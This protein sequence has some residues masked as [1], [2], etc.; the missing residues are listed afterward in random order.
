MKYKINDYDLVK[1]EDI[2]IFLICLATFVITAG[3]HLGSI[4]LGFAHVSWFRFYFVMAVLIYFIYRI[5]NQ[6]NIIIWKRNN[7]FSVSYIFVWVLYAVM[8]IIWSRNLEHFFSVLWFL[9]VGAL[10]TVIFVDICNIERIIKIIISFELGL[11]IQSVFGLYEIVTGKYFFLNEY[12]SGV[13]ASYRIPVAM[14]SNA[15]DYGTAMF[16]GALLA[17]FL[18]VTTTNKIQKIL[19]LFLMLDY[20]IMVYLSGSRAAL[21]GF[22]FAIGILVW[23]N[24]SDGIRGIIVILLLI[25]FILPV[26]RNAFIGHL[27]FSYYTTKGE[28]FSV[29][30]NLIKNGLYF[31]VKTFGLGVGN[32]QIELWMNDSAMYY[33]KNILNMHNWWLEILTAYGIIIFLGFLLFYAKLL[34]DYYFYYLNDRKG[35]MGKQALIMFSILIGYSITS[36][37]SSSNVSK[38]YIWLF[39]AICITFQG[40][41]ITEK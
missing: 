36:V 31:V 15:N 34:I 14:L 39:W 30:T 17:I 2:I 24:A 19:C 40:I 11:F 12:N 41:C 1:I 20:G 3:T 25:L 7:R 29:R 16:F 10:L 18:F 37:S 13:Y 22:L 9:F 35:I 33:T 8:S 26:T 5:V 32:G 21:I 38:E 23:N 4:N 27:N 6:D 28:S